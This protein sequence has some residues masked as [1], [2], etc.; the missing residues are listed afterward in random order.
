[1]HQLPKNNT[2]L[3]A[4]KSNQSPPYRLMTCY[5]RLYFS[6]G[7]QIDKVCSTYWKSIGWAIWASI[8]KCSQSDLAQNV[9]SIWCKIITSFWTGGKWAILKLVLAVTSA[10]RRRKTVAMP[11]IKVIVAFK[12][13]TMP[14]IKGTIAFKTITMPIKRSPYS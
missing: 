1:M 14:V 13:V 5:L 9:N 7:A 4:Q 2:D 11:F 6:I 12:T 10:V 3:E 8:K